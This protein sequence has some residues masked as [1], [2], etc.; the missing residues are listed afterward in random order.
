MGLEMMPCAC[1][2]LSLGKYIHTWTAQSRGMWTPLP[3]SPYLQGAGAIIS[4]ISP[5]GSWPT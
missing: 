3:P 2:S 5:K 1:Y 4:S